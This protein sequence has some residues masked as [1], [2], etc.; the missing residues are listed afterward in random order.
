[1]ASPRVYFPASSP[2]SFAPT[3]P[4]SQLLG[5]SSVTQG[6]GGGSSVGL[7]E[8]QDAYLSELLSYSLDRLNKEPELL[9]ADAERVQ[10]Q[11]QEVAVAHYR[12]FITAADAIRSIHRE[13][14]SVDQHLGSLV[15]GIPKLTT[16]CNEFLEEAQGVMEKRRLNKTM[17]ATHPTLMD[18]LEIPQLMDTCVRN[19]NYDEA[20]D[21]EAFV[22]KLATTHAKLPVIQQLA[23]EVRHTTQAMLSQLLLR[24]RSN[25]QLPE[26]LRVIGYLRRLAVFSETEMRLQPSPPVCLP[27]PPHLSYLFF[28][29]SPCFSPPF[30][31]LRCREAWLGEVVSELDPASPYDYLKRLTDCHRVHLFDVA[32]QYHAIFAHHSSS[33]PDSSNL[34]E[35]SAA[36]AALLG[37]G[38]VGGG[39][40]G[41]AGGV[42]GKYGKGRAGGGAVLNGW[43]GGGAGGD[44]G[45]VYGWAMH[46][47]AV[48][49][50]ALA[51]HL[52]RI[53]DGGSLASVLEHCMYCGMSLGRVG[54]DLRGLLP[55]LFESCVLRMFQRNISFAVDSFHHVLET[56]RW[57]PLPSMGSAARMGL[58]GESLDDVAPPYSLM[59]H[60][61][62]AAFVNGILAA[63]N[64]LRHCAPTSLK[65]QLA[66]EV[67]RALAVVAGSL[68]RYSHTHIVKDSEAA[69]FISTCKA[70]VEVVCPYVAVCFSRC[71]GSPA[72]LVSTQAACEPVKQ[73]ILASMPPAAAADADA[74]AAGVDE[75]QEGG[76][77]AEGR[78]GDG[79]AGEGEGGKGEEKVGEGV[80]DGSGG[81]LVG[82]DLSA[83]MSLLE[84]KYVPRP[85]AIGQGCNLDSMAEE[86]PHLRELDFCVNAD[87]VHIENKYGTFIC[88]PH[89][90]FPNQVF[91]SNP[92]D[93]PPAG[94]YRQNGGEEEPEDP[95]VGDRSMDEV[96]VRCWAKGHYGGS[97]IMAYDPLFNWD[98]ERAAVIG[99]RLPIRPI[100]SPSVGTRFSVRILG[101]TV[102]A[103]LVEPVS[104]TM[105]LYHAERREK[106]SEDFHFQFLPAQWEGESTSPDT[107]AIFSVDKESAALCLLVQLDKA[108]SEESVNGIKPAV[109]TR[110]DPP[111]LTDK[112]AAR[113]SEWAQV[114]PFR[115]PLAWITIPLFDSSVTGG[116]G[117]FGASGGGSSG[118]GSSG[119]LGGGGGVLGVEGGGMGGGA[120][121][122]PVVDSNGV[123]VPAY[124]LG[125][126]PVQIDIP[127]LNRAKECYT[128]DQLLDPK[129][130]AQKPVRVSMHFEDPKKKAQK[131]VRVSMHFEVERLPGGA[132]GGAAAGG[133]VT[134][135]SLSSSASQRGVNRARSQDSMTSDLDDVNMVPRSLS[136]SRFLT[137][138]PLLLL[139]SSLPPMHFQ[140]QTYTFQAI[141]FTDMFQAIDFTDMVLAEPFTR[142]FQAIDFTDM[143]RAEPFTRLFQ[144]IDFTDMVRAEPFTRLV[145]LLFVY[146]QQVAL[147]KK[148]NLFVRTELRADDLDIQR[149]SMEVSR[150]PTTVCGGSADPTAV[151]GAS[152]QQAA[153]PKKLKLFVHTELQADD[154]DIQRPSM[155][156]IFPKERNGPMLRTA[157][158]QVVQGA[159]PALFHDEAIFPKERNG[160]MLRTASTQVVQGA[161]PALFHDEVKMQLPAS[162][163]PAHHLLFTFFHIDLSLRS[164]RPKPVSGGTEHRVA[165]GYAVM[166]LAAAL[167]AFK[168]EVNLPISKDL[169]PRYLQESTKVRTSSWVGQQVPPAW[170][171]ERGALKVPHGRGAINALKTAP[172][173]VLMAPLSSS[174]PLFLFPETT[175]YPSSFPPPHPVPV[176]ADLLGGREADIPSPHSPLL[177]A[178]PTLRPPARLLPPVRPPH[179]G[180][181]LPREDLLE[182]INALKTVDVVV[183]MQFL[184]PLLNMLLCMIGNGVETLQVAAFRAMI[185]IV[186][187]WV[188]VKAVDVVVLMQFLYPLLNML[189]CM[190]GNGVETLQVAAF[191]AMINIVSRGH[192]SRCLVHFVSTSSLALPSLCLT[193][194]P[195]QP[196][197]L[198]QSRVHLELAPQTGSAPMERSR[199]LPTSFLSVPH[200][201]STHPHLPTPILS[202]SRVQL[203]LAPQAGAAAMEQS[204][205]LVHFVNF[206]FH[207]L[208]LFVSPLPI[209]T[210]QLELAPQTGSAPMERSRFLVHFVDFIFDD[211]GRNQPPVYPGLSNVWR[212]LA[213]SKSRGFRVGPVYAEA[214]QMAWFVLELIVKSMDLELAQVPQGDEIARLRLE[215]EVFLCIRQ[216][217][218]CLLAEV[219][220]KAVSDPPLAKSLSSSISFFC[221]DLI[222]V[223]D[224]PQVFELVGLFLSQFV[225]VCPPMQHMF[226]LHFLRIVCDHDLYI[227]TPGRGP[228][229]KNYLTTV[230]LKDLFVS[231]DHEDPSQRSLAARML[232]FQV[233]KHEYDARYQQPELKLY[234]AQLYM[235]IV[236]MILDEVETFHTLG[237]IQRR[238]ILVVMLTVVR[239]LDNETLL[240]AWKQSDVRTRLF[241]TLLQQA[242]VLFQHPPQ[243]T[244]GSKPRPTAT[245]S[246]PATSA[247]ADATLAVE[248]PPIPMY[249]D[250][251]SLATNDQL[252]EMARADPKALLE[253]EQ[254]IRKVT[255]GA[256]SGGKGSAVSLRDVLARSRIPP[257]DAMA[258][259]RQNLPPSASGKLLTWEASVAAW[260]AVQV[261]EVV[262]K[263]SDM[264]ADGLVATDYQTMDCLTGPLSVML[265]LPQPMSFWE[266][267]V[268][269]FAE[270]LRL[271]G[272][273]MLDGPPSAAA[274]DTADSAGAAAKGGDVL[275]KGLFGSLLKQM[276]LRPEFIRKR[277]LLCLLLLLRNA[278]LHMKDVERLRVI[279]TVA[280]S[281]VL[282]HMRLLHAP[283]PS[284]APASRSSS[285]SSIAS[286][287]G[288][289]GGGAGELVESAEVEKLRLSLEELGTEDKWFQLLDECGL[290]SICLEIVVEED[291]E[292]EEEEDEEDEEEEYEEWDE[293][294]SVMVGRRRKRERDRWTWA[295]VEETQDMLLTVVDAASQHEQLME[296]LKTSNDKYAIVESYYILAQA[297]GHVPDLYIMWM[298]HLC[299]AHQEMNQWAEAAQCA[300]SVAGIVIRGLQIA[301]EEPV[302][303]EE[304]LEVLWSICPLARHQWRARAFSSQSGFGAARVTVEGAVQ[305]VQR[306]SNLFYKAELF[307]FCALMLSLLLPLHRT[308]HDYKQLTK[309][310]NKIASIY[311]NVEQQETS[312]IP[313]KDACYYR[314]GFYGERF[315]YIDG[316]QFI[317]R[318]SR[319]VRLGDIMEKLKALYD[320]RSPDEEP[321]QIIQDSRQ[322]HPASLKPRVHLFIPARPHAHPSPYSSCTAVPVPRFPHCR[323]FI[324][325]EPRDVRL[326]DIMEKLKALY[327][328]RSPDE[329]PLQIIQDSRQV[330]PAA[331]KPN[332]VYMQITAVEPVVG[333]G[334]D[335][336]LGRPLEPPIAGTPTFSCFFFDTPFT[337][338]GKQQGRMEDQWKR[339]TLLYT[340]STLPSLISRQ[341]V[342]RSE[343]REYSPIQCAVEIIES[344]S[345]ALEAEMASQLGD[346][347]AAGAAGGPAGKKDP[348][349]VVAAAMAAGSGP[350][351]L[352]RLQTLQRLLQGSVA[353]QVNSGVLGVCMA[354]YQANPQGANP[355]AKDP[356]KLQPSELEMLTSA[357]VRFVVVCKRAVVVH[358]RAVTEE[359]RD[360]QEQLEQSLE[361]LEKEISAFIPGLRKRASAY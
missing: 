62:L 55:P 260:C 15:S 344:R 16:G 202:R 103:G 215:D 122:S 264:A 104:G 79:E 360:F 96:S 115:E 244:A 289:A 318:E 316:R 276:A 307:H 198:S 165:V 299:D 8:L 339:R 73:L 139:L 322:V 204:R 51:Q 182:A 223:V 194:R 248:P 184:Y 140:T 35:D 153:L 220:E 243:L 143:V 2:R 183:L 154:L 89:L 330:D 347:G 285:A 95:Y 80:R 181:A 109:Y 224:P 142:L 176:A 151:I 274:A 320:A 308:R 313:F 24:L 314:V 311:E 141:D 105:C 227:E 232:A 56:H 64:E 338:N 192:R 214:L 6:S 298:L 11:M 175:P 253:R 349:A 297:Y 179:A 191:R 7:E 14:N 21:L 48:Y 65:Q 10:R 130:K 125:G 43:G 241:F 137:G 148:L 283:S 124:E 41:G 309:T 77:A 340:Q 156:A 83:A 45:L 341:P 306:A 136:V 315:R 255:G 206:V 121:S 350:L 288:G 238:Q 293:G 145:H 210:V 69:L 310:H 302:W 61:P 57:V 158:T 254:I 9:R 335:R 343:V 361:D 277:A 5:D 150:D 333:A 54:L 286:A 237:V 188:L 208:P 22:A 92:S 135:R 53:E 88:E 116:V 275:L 32:T 228:T 177:V 324:Y 71:Y 358:G 1:M 197:L 231:L 3:T 236:N 328:A 246:S 169:Q 160:P 356:E 203:E 258:L 27:P 295:N 337:P 199:A 66:G 161:R 37:D 325:R 162:V 59:E 205:F 234:I 186:S 239:N 134:P 98:S 133:S 263:F 159:R 168:A 126:P 290:P 359:D 119:S 270:M 58:G 259:M 42:L 346:S 26:C 242:L 190:I 187:R 251:V 90:S 52:P 268:P 355:R 146:P 332:L 279:L 31:F 84:I 256:V 118:G 63:L 28:P 91:P 225:G 345:F 47:V 94:S 36:L 102:Q 34:D 49:L 67:E 200:S 149:P 128:D 196:A 114:M 273:A 93:A 195:L 216:L 19:G 163:T 281:E 267:L 97:T 226:K 272:K 326:G 99:H 87:F 261:L 75:G 85:P 354:F 40:G 294:G 29:R 357:I 111:T 30:Q 120:G 172:L 18:L 229:E 127:T 233:A 123:R 4:T 336:W 278:L 351:Q 33:S 76:E 201:T 212:S 173:V 131:P 39:A 348:A 327:D 68:G 217:F 257:K 171:G 249:S 138:P 342:V 221:Y 164:E 180:G 86:V 319:D 25:I 305:H 245:K 106:A 60:P 353:L 252:D 269:A 70:F 178:P 321:L 329:E 144:A 100:T 38:G 240:K 101:L 20:L 292:K 13:I 17:L 78:R 207:S 112:E 113:L 193:P 250:R 222:S 331:L 12:A 81:P 284:P 301:S 352:P 74:D 185:N 174:H 300:V 265:A 218:E 219:H 82:P 296:G 312:P 334:E 304:H 282:S 107:R 23:V 211:L 230:L 46:R 266:P 108:A 155:K 50:A 271:H 167:Q 170:C 189:L 117:G 280:L 317:Y 287:A 247:P 72:T 129:K 44:G 291:E 166:P 152:Q 209:S 262:E 213:R 235:P 132:A 157:S 110:K 303:D 147:P 323:E